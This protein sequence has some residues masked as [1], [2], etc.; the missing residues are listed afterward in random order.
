MIYRQKCFSDG[1]EQ[2]ATDSYGRSGM[3]RYRHSV[4]T[5]IELLVVIAII[6]I[7]AA[8]LLPALQQARER[9]RS[10]KC[11]NNLKQAGHAVSTYANDYNCLPPYSW[12]HFLGATDAAT[13]FRILM[14]TT[15]REDS[16]LVVNWSQATP[17]TG[18]PGV[19][20]YACPTAAASPEPP[21]IASSK[22]ITYGAN[23]TTTLYQSAVRLKL[24]IKNLSSFAYAGET[25]GSEAFYGDSANPDRYS[26]RHNK[27]M[28]VLFADMHVASRTQNSVMPAA[29]R[30]KQFW[31]AY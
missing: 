8:M 3:P 5:L 21:L 28:N 24:K 13:T 16:T 2:T 29:S 11:V 12:K 1:L 30:D 23:N 18:Y 31:Y 26:F 7:L 10:I 17:R 4:F 9:G 6:A 25:N 19:S 15:F 27:A 22:K 14:N 20:K